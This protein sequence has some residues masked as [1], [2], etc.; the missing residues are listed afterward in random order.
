MKTMLYKIELYT[1]TFRRAHNNWYTQK[2]NP[3]EE[4][5]LL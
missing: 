4:S 2:H 1:I 3:K 5:D